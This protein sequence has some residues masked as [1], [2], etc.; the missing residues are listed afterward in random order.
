MDMQ[1]VG[2]EVLN[3]AKTSYMTAL[4]TI[5]VIQ[6]QAERALNTLVQQGNIAQDEGK[7]VLNDWVNIA[8]KNR[9]EYQKM[10]EESL[11]RAESMFIKKSPK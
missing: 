2:T 5:T 3:F 8:R 6:D 4:G 9:Q 7:K 11:N 1:T 10:F